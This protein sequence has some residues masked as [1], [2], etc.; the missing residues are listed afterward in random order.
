MNRL[1]ST[2]RLDVTLQFRNALYYVG[3]FVVIVIVVFMRQ[4]FTS[5]EMIGYFMPVFFLGALPITTYFFVAGLVLFEKGEGILEALVVTP[6]RTWEY[7]VSK[8]V[9][10]TFLATLESLIVVFLTYGTGFKLLPFLA[11]VIFMGFVYTLIGFTLISRYDSITDFLMPSIV[12][13]VILELPLIHY[14]G[15]WDHINPVF[16]LWPTQA[17]LLLIKAAFHPIE[18]WQMIY[19]VLYSILCIVPIY[20]LAHKSMYRFIIQKERSW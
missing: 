9:T 2:I 15:L 18:T 16:Y 14:F 1:L 12:Y 5:K 19:A 20:L 13:T 8:T 6:L 11:G 10:L 7:L 17:Q 4:I 3:A